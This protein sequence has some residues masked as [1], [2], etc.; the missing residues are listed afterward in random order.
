MFG[1]MAAQCIYQL[2]SLAHEQVSG[3]EQHGTRLLLL[4][5]HCDKA[6]SGA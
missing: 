1:E 3:A 4:G 2:G 6:Q 5:L